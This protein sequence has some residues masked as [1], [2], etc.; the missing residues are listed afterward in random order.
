[1]REYDFNSYRIKM[2]TFEKAEKIID[3]S[4]TLDEAYKKIHNER[5][6]AV[7]EFLEMERFRLSRT[8]KK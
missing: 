7:S 4:K 8:G 3:E 2:S 5:F 6:K 1:M